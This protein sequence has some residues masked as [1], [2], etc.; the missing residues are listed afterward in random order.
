MAYSFF[1]VQNKKWKIAVRKLNDNMLLNEFD[2][3]AFDF[4]SW[5]PDSKNLIYT[6]PEILREG[7]S[8][9]LQPLDNSASKLILDTKND[10]ILWADWSNDGQKLYFK[11]G[12]TISNIVLMNKQSSN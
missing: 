4:V 10:K 7:G 3:A 8:L 9:W 6:L 5:T 1:D 12:K 11:K 2:A